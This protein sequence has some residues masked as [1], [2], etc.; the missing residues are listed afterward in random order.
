MSWMKR[1][2]WELIEN[3]EVEYLI[4]IGAP[5]WAV[6]EAQLFAQRELESKDNDDTRAKSTVCC[7]L[8]TTRALKKL[9]RTEQVSSLTIKEHILYNCTIGLGQTHTLRA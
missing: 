6:E 1:W 9:N 2:L 5:K 8:S 3:G 4:M 7:L